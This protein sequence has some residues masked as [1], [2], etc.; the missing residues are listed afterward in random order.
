[1]KDMNFDININDYDKVVFGT[2]EYN[3]DIPIDTEAINIISQEAKKKMSKE[4]GC[5]EE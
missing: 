2:H 3:C 4:Y 1:M 5:M